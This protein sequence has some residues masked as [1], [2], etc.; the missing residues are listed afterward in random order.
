MR[1]KRSDTRLLVENWRS[2]INENLNLSSGLNDSSEIEQ[3]HLNNVFME[4]VLSRAIVQLTLKE[5]Y[6]EQE[7]DWRESLGKPTDY[8]YSEE[9]ILEKKG[10][11]SIIKEYVAT[12][13]LEGEKYSVENFKNQLRSRELNYKNLKVRI[14]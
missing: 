7:D 12:N 13:N 4:G 11:N 5:F 9:G 8:Y 6:I 2:L 1:M 14:K 3:H 10:L